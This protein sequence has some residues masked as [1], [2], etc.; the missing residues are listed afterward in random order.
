MYL[1]LNNISESFDLDILITGASGFVGKHLIDKLS[2]KKDKILGL[3]LSIDEKSSDRNI[4]LEEVDI[5][6]PDKVESIIERLKPSRIFHL[7]AQSS[8]KNSWQ[9]PIETFRI[10][11]FG[12]INIL[13]AVKKYSPGSKVLVVCTAEEYGN[14]NSPGEA[15]KETDKLNP[16]NPY[17]ISKAALD[18][19]STTY[20]KAYG[21]N[22]F[23][24][25]SF[26]HMGPGQSERF[27]CSDFAKQIALIEKGE[28]PPLIR[29]GNLGSYRDFLDVRDVV[30]AYIKIV[31][32]AKPG[33]V[34]NVCSSRKTKIKKI[35]EILLSLST[36][37]DI[38]I[39]VD[40]HRLRPIDTDIVFGDNTR[41]TQDTGWGPQYDLD[42][43][44]KDTLQWWRKKVNKKT[45]EVK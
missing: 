38:K 33:V 4:D 30:S 8:V 5:K 16:S 13:E 45:K 21:L 34:Y 32:R 10:N 27:V 25:R 12:G 15:I 18:F 31:E 17:A 44:L 3:D 14:G 37:D 29:V 39:E 20:N 36:R 43:S 40:K 35:L 41:L 2:E 1:L 42:Q 9:D 11:V 23:V 28:L 24:S 7:A 26:N 22:V 19:F 6:D